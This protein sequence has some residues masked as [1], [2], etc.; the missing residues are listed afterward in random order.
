M[1][2]HLRPVFDPH[3]VN[4]HALASIGR[5]V[6]AVGTFA[7][8]GG[9]AVALRRAVKTR[10]NRILLFGAPAIAGIIAAHR[11]VLWQTGHPD[12]AR[13]LSTDA[14]LLG[15]LGLSQ[16][17]MGWPAQ[18]GGAYSV[19]VALAILVWP[20]HALQLF[21][22]VTLVYP[23]LFVA[24]GLPGRWMGWR[25]GRTTAVNEPS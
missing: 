6:D 25:R 23:V 18:V 19:A 1:R 24:R 15:G 3:V 7:L 22:T 4:K 11:L 16:V 5:A 21:V 17:N 9:L 2:T 14:L 13:A 8:T 10:D 20:Q 12:V